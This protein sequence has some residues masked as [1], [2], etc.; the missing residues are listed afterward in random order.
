[1]KRRALLSSALLGVSL[2]P[3]L[4]AA[5]ASASAPGED[6]ADAKV[7]RYAFEIAE[8]GFDPAQVEDMYSRVI[9]AHI[10]EGLYSYDYL[11]RP[12]MLKAVTAAGDPQPSADFKTWTVRIRPGI[13]FADDPAFKGAKREL[14]AEDYVYSIKRVADPAVESSSWGEIE[15]I[16]LLGLAEYRTEVVKAK[17]AFDYAHDIEGLRALDRYTLQFRLREARPRLMFTFAQGDL[18]GAVAR[19]VIE[20]NAGHTMEHPIGT[21]PFRLTQWRRSSLIVLERNPNYR[22]RFYDQEVEP[23]PDDAE[24]QALQARFKGR[25]LPLVDRVE[26]SIIEEQQPRWLAFLNGQFDLMYKMP[27]PFVPQA[28]PHGKIA[29]NLQ[30]KG[31]QGYQTLMT[32]ITYHVFNMEDP[33][34]GGYT[35]EKVALR[36]ALSL[37]LDIE[38]E[39]R[40]LR[41]GLAVPAQSFISPGTSGYD[42]KF[43]SELSDFDPA[44]A[45]ALLDLYGYVDRDGDGWRELPDGRPLLI[46]SMTTAD[47]KQRPF[48]ELWQK[49][50][51]AIG[52]NVVFKPGQWPEN[53]KALQSGKYQMWSLALGGSLPDGQDPA[54]GFMTNMIGSYNHSRFSMPALDELFARTGVMADGPEREALFLR[55][56]RLLIAYVPTRP[57]CHRVYTDLA[58]RQL[59][60]YRRPLLWNNWWEYVDI[61]HRA[62]QA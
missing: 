23:A 17:K 55:A 22:E 29:P 7:L 57:H 6:V 32:D 26:V 13:H 53:L 45:N 11:A 15:D 4:A 10:F 14:T 58:Q 62:V 19:E 3:A 12:P 47:A 1:M 46:Q 33:V 39:I 31:I 2:P 18:Y 5:R 61:D 42:P 49:N 54:A 37:A 25:R 36:R 43:K 21:G 20:A 24:G 59:L 52:I 60:G 44:R 48:D 9:T 34:I 50:W 41:R 28:M 40:L 27:E 8:T 35:P 16:G 56:K 51:A 30:K 38:R